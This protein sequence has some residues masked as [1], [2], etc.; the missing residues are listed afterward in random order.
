M[1]WQEIK[2][3]LIK[4]MAAKISKQLLKLEKLLAPLDAP[5]KGEPDS[6]STGALGNF[7][8]KFHDCGGAMAD[9]CNSSDCARILKRCID[10]TDCKD[11]LISLI[12]QGFDPFCPNESGMPNTGFG[13]SL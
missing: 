11:A 4:K 5:S 12:A 2:Y 8:F 10:V 7:P 6:D 3:I 13:G 9:L 1:S